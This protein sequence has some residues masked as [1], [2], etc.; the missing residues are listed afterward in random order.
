MKHVILYLVVITLGFSPKSFSANKIKP[1]D[2]GI[3]L[4]K[5]QIDFKKMSATMKET[6]VA[7]T[8]TFEDYLMDIAVLSKI[9]NKITIYKN[10]GNG[11]LDIYNTI[12]LEKKARKIEAYI[13]KD[14]LTTFSRD[15]SLKI[16]YDNGD[17]S[18]INNKQINSFSYE[19]EPRVPK[20][21]FLNDARAFLY[22]ISF[23]EQWRSARNG[24]PHNWV[25]VGDLD[26]DGKNEA[27]YTFYPIND[28]IPQYSPATIVVFENVSQNQ[29][30]IDWDTTLYYNGAF[31]IFSAVTDFD[32]D[33]NKE[34]FA[35]GNDFLGN[36]QLGL[37][38]CTG[39]GKYKFRFASLGGLAAPLD[40]EIKDSVTINGI[41]KPEL[42]LCESF[43]ISSGPSYIL[44]YRFNSKGALA[45]SFLNVSPGTPHVNWLVYS[46]SADDID[47]DGKYEIILGD[48]QFGTN[49]I[50]Y[51]D[52]TGSGNFGY[53][54]KEIIPNAPISTG[55]SFHKDYDDDGHKEI[56]TCGIGDGSGSIGILKHT[57]LP[58]QNQFTTMWWD[59]S[60]IFSSPNM[61]IDTNEIDHQFSILYPNVRSSGPIYWLQI[62]T[63]TKNE[64]F[65][66]YKSCFQVIDSA[67]LLHPVLFDMDSDNKMN[68]I[69]SGGFNGPP[70]KLGLIDFEQNG[71]LNIIS[72]NITLSKGFLLEQN[73][74]NPFNAATIINY[75]LDVNS[76]ITLKVYNSLGKEIQTL[77]NQKQNSGSYSKVFESGNFS[78]GIY[79]YSLYSDKNLID[80]KK[81]LLIK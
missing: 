3:T 44:R 72:N 40:I 32:K 14:Y 20:W 19:P 41:T 56:T 49:Y 37:Y 35:R 54:V 36:L 57:G 46:I 70:F 10:L 69:S 39:E 53:E 2:L 78:S 81:M 58:G 59:S 11:Y 1:Q 28:T 66:F 38:E 22:D 55:W 76:Y 73:Y 21:N 67:A 24:Q 51:F 15:Y 74:P 26:N 27:V 23:V 25:A 42:W 13:P 33:G 4:T 31:N 34:F 64:I 79:F 62:H 29:Y 60:G 8:F 6:V 63:F 45:Y 30:R 5:G 71:V 80:T 48:T 16:L 12:Q 9:N 17:E 77:V 47:N 7:S 43:L 50:D 75:K 52:S 65:N 18:I 68:I 61:G